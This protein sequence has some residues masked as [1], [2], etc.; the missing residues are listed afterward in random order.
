[1]QCFDPVLIQLSMSRATHGTLSPPPSVSYQYASRYR[2]LFCP[3]F[4]LI[5]CENVDSL[6]KAAFDTVFRVCE[7]F[8]MNPHPGG[9]L[10]TVPIV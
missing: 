6:V 8:F 5:P 7:Y 3:E 1:M 2:V 9:Q 4:A 10:I